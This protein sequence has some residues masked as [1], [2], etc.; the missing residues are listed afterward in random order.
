MPE[1]LHVQV[2]VSGKIGV[3]TDTK[4]TVVVGILVQIAN[5]KI[6]YGVYDPLLDQPDLPVGLP[7]E[8]GC[9]VGSRDVNR[10]KQARCAG[11]EPEYGRLGRGCGQINQP[12]SKDTAH[13]NYH[14]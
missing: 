9:R 8:Q 10:V 7:H 14:P 1:I 6:R 12:K 13:I 11:S 2:A 5:I 4:N 3:E